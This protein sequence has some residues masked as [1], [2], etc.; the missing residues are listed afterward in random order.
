ME[1]IYGPIAHEFDYFNIF[2]FINKIKLDNSVLT[3]AKYLTEVYIEYVKKISSYSSGIIDIFLTKAFY[4]EIKDSNLIENHLIY[5]EEVLNNDCYFDCFNISKDRIKELHKFSERV[6]SEYNFRT[7]DAWV[8]LLRGNKQIIYWYGAK[9]KD[10]ERFMDDFI[11][12]YKDDT[13]FENLLIKS[14]LIHLIF[15]KIH[16]FKD[17]NGRTARLI[18]DMKFTELTNKIFNTDFRIS[19]LHISHSISINKSE[20]NKR[21]DSLCFDLEHFDNEQVNKW[22]NFMLNMYG[23]QLFYMENMLSR[24]ETQLANAEMFSNNGENKDEVIKILQFDKGSY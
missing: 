24:N 3:K 7:I 18:S 6:V 19:P 16:P 14:I 22:F 4:E 5:P 13:I 8:R 2:D 9:P 21:L 10:V 20:Y 11:K 1:T 12:L 15:I 17:G 23:E